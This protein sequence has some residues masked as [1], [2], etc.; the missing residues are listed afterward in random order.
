MSKQQ[1][2]ETI[3]K[4]FKRTQT[5]RNEKAIEDSEHTV[6]LSLLSQTINTVRVEI[7]K[8]DGHEILSFCH[9]TSTQNHEQGCCSCLSK[10]RKHKQ[11]HEK[12]KL[13]EQLMKAQFVYLITYA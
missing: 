1:D 7:I 9:D 8:D 12:E 11:E 6:Y 10:S 5:T 13:Q 2:E 4:K 3:R